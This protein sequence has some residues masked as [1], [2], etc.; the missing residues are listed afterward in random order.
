VDGSVARVFFNLAVKVVDTGRVGAT[1][2]R[3]GRYP[4]SESGER[5][6]DYNYACDQCD[7]DLGEL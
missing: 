7:E 3:D 5:A 4:I 1:V 2:D 6:A